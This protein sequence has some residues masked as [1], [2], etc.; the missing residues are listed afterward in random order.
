[1]RLRV[2][3]I[4]PQG[5][6]VMLARLIVLVGAKQQIGK[7]DMPHGILGMMKDRFRI[8]AA[9]GVDGAHIRQQCPEFVERAEI[10]RGPAQ[11]IDEGGLGVLSPVEGA[12][13]NCAL[14]L[15]IAGVALDA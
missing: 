8:D 9:G 11:D 7:V 15:G 2:I 1:M 14:D 6:F 4:D 12:E 10:G 5:S 13:Q 3:R